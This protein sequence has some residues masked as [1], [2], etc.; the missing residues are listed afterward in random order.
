MAININNNE[1]LEVLYI[2]TDQESIPDI[3]VYICE[4]IESYRVLK[5]LSILSKNLFRLTEKYE[6]LIDINNDNFNLNITLSATKFSLYQR[7]QIL[8]VIESYY[9]LSGQDIT[10]SLDKNEDNKNYLKNDFNGIKQIYL[11]SKE[12]IFRKNEDIKEEHLRRIF[13]A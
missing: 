12:R 5:K 2:Y 3:C 10:I 9:E 4:I 13:R 6:S 1:N 11:I 7:I 8:T